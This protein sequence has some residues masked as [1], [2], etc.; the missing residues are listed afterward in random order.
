MIL[1][2]VTNEEVPIFNFNNC[3]EIIIENFKGSEHKNVFELKTTSKSVAN[4][5]T[6]QNIILSQI[7]NTTPMFDFFKV[8]NIIIGQVNIKNTEGTEPIFKF[9]NC[10]QISIDNLT[11]E[12]H[13]NAI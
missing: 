9:I 8:L 4:S 2:K 11:A 12:V 5:I 13:K 1:N 6:I 7:T 10:D 3:P